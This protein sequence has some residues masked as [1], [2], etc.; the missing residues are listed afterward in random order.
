MNKVMLFK[1]SGATCTG[2]KIAIESFVSKM[3]GV[4]DVFIDGSTAHIQVVV[5]EENVSEVMNT[6]PSIVKKLGYYAEFDKM[7]DA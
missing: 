1:L 6:V 7:D 5:S 4:E 3:E 2:C